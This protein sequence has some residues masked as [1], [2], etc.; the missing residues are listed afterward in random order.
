[1]DACAALKWTSPSAIQRESL[2]HALS[3]RDIIGLAETG[4]GKTGAFGLPVLQGLLNHDGSRGLFALVLAPTRELAFQITET[5]EALGAGIGVK[6]ATV[7]GGVDM[8]EQAIAL[9]KRPHIVVA[10]PGRIV[11]HLE[12]TRGFHLRNLHYFILDE[13]DRLL[14]MDFE[15]EINQII[16]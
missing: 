12:N 3:G 5:F 4:S 11:D 15:K 16:L 1:M 9:A 14:N 7:V 6:V 10:T 8:M 13:A 2:P